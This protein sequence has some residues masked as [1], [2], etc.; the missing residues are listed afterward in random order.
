MNTQLTLKWTE[1]WNIASIVPTTGNELDEVRPIATDCRTAA[2]L[3]GAIDAL[4]ADLESIRA[5][6][7]RRFAEAQ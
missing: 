5:E 6:G 7:R 3:D 4:I 2:Q 1:G